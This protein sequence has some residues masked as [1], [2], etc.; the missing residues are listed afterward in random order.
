[1][2]DYLFGPGQNPDDSAFDGNWHT[3]GVRSHV[4]APASLI[5][6][7]AWYGPSRPANHWWLVFRMSDEAIVAELN[8]FAHFGGGS[9]L[10]DWNTFLAA[11]FTIPG[12]VDLDDGDEYIPAVATNGDFSFNAAGSYPVGSGLG[13]GTAAR[14][15][16]AGS[17]PL[18]PT[19]QNT[20]DWFGAD[21]LVQPAGVDPNEGTGAFA[22]ELA[23]AASGLTERRGDASLAIDMSLAA[24]GQ[25]EHRGSGAFPLDISL[26]AE[27]S[28]PAQGTAAFFIDLSLAAEARRDTV[29]PTLSAST[30]AATLTA[31]STGPGLVAHT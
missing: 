5:G 7:R 16:N 30:A 29:T 22:I 1:M 19:G 14:F 6:G 31:T 3:F 12:A 26:A 10:N 27:G 8:L 15:I 9:T 4:T 18:F 24:T 17:G 28:R 21:M 2:A 23:L 25:A 13:I 11:V 20:T